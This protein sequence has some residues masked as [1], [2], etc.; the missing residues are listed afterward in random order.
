MEKI[1][2]RGNRQKRKDLERGWQTTEKKTSHHPYAPKEATG[3]D[4]RNKC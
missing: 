2:R 1:C 4:G 3:D